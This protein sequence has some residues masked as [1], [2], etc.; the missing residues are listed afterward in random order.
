MKIQK[1]SL[2]EN[3]NKATKKHPTSRQGPSCEYSSRSTQIEDLTLKKG[4]RLNLAPCMI[5]LKKPTKKLAKSMPLYKNNL[6]LH[7]KKTCKGNHK[8]Q[9]DRESFP[10]WKTL[11]E[12]KNP[13]SILR[14][15]LC[16]HKW[17]NKF[18]YYL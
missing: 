2:L 15:L 12:S 6:H 9:R 18:F 10:L 1:I 3:H 5:R 13:F 14:N 8:Q 4:S 17:W 11:F 7:E 16:T